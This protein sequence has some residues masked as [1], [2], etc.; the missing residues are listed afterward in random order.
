MNKQPQKTSGAY[1]LSCRKKNQKNKPPIPLPDKSTCRCPESGRMEVQ[2]CAKIVVLTDLNPNLTEI[3]LL[4]RGGG[5]NGM[6]QDSLK[7][8]LYPLYQEDERT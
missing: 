5:K 2:L 4:F 1:I 3:V 8:V 6:I 7:H